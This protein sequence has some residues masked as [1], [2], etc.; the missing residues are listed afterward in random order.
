MTEQEIKEI[1]VAW[2]SSF[3]T[4][5]NIYREAQRLCNKYNWEL[6]SGAI[7]YCFIIPDTDFVI[8]FPKYQHRRYI[9]NCYKELRMY[10][11]AKDKYNCVELFPETSFLCKVNGIPFFKQERITI[12]TYNLRRE[13]KN[14]IPNRQVN[15]KYKRA[16]G[17]DTGIESAW[18]ERA[19][20]VYGY[21]KVEALRHM[22]NKYHIN[23]LHN[24]NT[25][26]IGHRPVL[27]DFGGY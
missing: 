13:G 6:F 8:K 15:E 3:S 2:F 12:T 10:N 20:V 21:K 27:L 26:Y 19:I 5:Y 7:K 23:D 17:R 14:I 22:I 11:L 9:A 4:G 24:K 25:G 18:I 16:I 1:I